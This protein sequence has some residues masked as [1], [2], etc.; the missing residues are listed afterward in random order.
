[1]M[2]RENKKRWICD[3]IRKIRRNTNLGCILSKNNLD[4]VVF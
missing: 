2:K 4:C 1:M 3:E